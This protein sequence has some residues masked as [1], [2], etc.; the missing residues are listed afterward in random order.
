MLRYSAS[1]AMFKLFSLSPTTRN[2]YR[3][4]G[5]RFETWR[6]AREGLPQRYIDRV[7]LLLSCIERHVDLSHDSQVLEIGTGFVHWE[8][9]ICTVSADITSTMYDIVDNR[10]FATFKLYASELNTH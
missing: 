4:F 8:T 7:S 1:S 5:N 3:Q 10:L 6:R 9:L 2:Y